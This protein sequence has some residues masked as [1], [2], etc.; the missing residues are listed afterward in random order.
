MDEWE[1]SSVKI[2]HKLNLQEGKN[3]ED[4]RPGRPLPKDADDTPPWVPFDGRTADWEVEVREKE[5]KSMRDHPTYQFVMLL[6]GFTN[7]KMSKYWTREEA[8]S[9]VKRKHTPQ[10]NRCGTGLDEELNANASRNDETY[11]NWYTKTSWA[12]G[13]IYLTPMVYGHLEESLTALTQ[14]YKHLRDATL[15][16]FMTSP[17]IRTLFARLVGMGI[18]V[19]DVLS[20]KKYSLDS[21][22]KRVNMERNR[23]MNVFRHVKL[24]KGG[25]TWPVTTSTSVLMFDKDTVNPT[26]ASVDTKWDMAQGLKLNNELLQ[27]N[28]RRKYLY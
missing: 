14:R 19:S 1:E 13:M 27:L 28:K 22:Y 24:V 21:T 16:D 11:H 2:D 4:I 7:E 3:Y 9:G 23:L 18:L 5:I 8:A 20:G 10:S 12:D 17:R 6:A 15:R 25:Q 26:Y